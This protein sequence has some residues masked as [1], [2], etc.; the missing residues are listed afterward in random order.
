MSPQSSK[1]F[2][3]KRGAQSPPDDDDASTTVFATPVPHVSAEETQRGFAI[4]WFRPA[5]PTDES[6]EVPVTSQGNGADHGRNLPSAPPP[7][8]I[9]PTAIVRVGPVG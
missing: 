6:G 8:V 2:T 4:P 9:P 3:T 7:M 5:S 1:T